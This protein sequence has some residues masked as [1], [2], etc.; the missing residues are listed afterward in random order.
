M[1][2]LQIFKSEEFGQVRT[3][4]IDGKPYF[5]GVDIATALEYSRP[6]KAVSDHCK[7]ILTQDT[8]KN[9][10]GYE[11]KLI[12]EGDIYRL[13]V[14]AS[15]Q[16]V[17]PGI[18]EKAERFASWVFDEV[19]PSIR[20]H[21]SYI[22]KPVSQDLQILQGMLNQLIQQDIE[23]KEA[24]EQSQKAISQVESIREVVALNPTDWR[25]ETSSLINK[26]AKNC[27]GNE[28]IKPIREESYKLLDQRFGV[29]L[30]IRLTNKKKTLS[31]NGAN[32]ST[33][34]KLN[35]LD[36][37]AEDKK[38]VEGYTQIIK[39]LAIKYKVA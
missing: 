33:L 20:Q 35:Y 25:R 14:K 13:V 16:S 30:S 37:I 22:S 1:N 10:G 19:L 23:I 29:S 34:D 6:S 2:D 39:E 7:G 21:G 17:N 11:E 12:P 9:S 36:V 28:H 38:L 4:E 26:M 32:K 27:G 8:I 5:Y 15:E 18:K 24:K 3:L 31:L